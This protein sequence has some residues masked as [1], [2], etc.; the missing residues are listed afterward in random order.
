MKIKGLTI[1]TT[2]QFVKRNF[3]DRYQE[4]IDALPVSSKA[5]MTNH[6]VVNEWYPIVESLT[7]PLRM[8]GEICYNSDWKKA[9][10]EMGR[11]DAE[12]ALTGIYKLYVRLGSPSHLISR[13]GRIMAAYYSDAELKLVHSEK[14]KV[15]LHIIRF[16]QADEAIEYNMAGWIQR[17]LEIS[18]CKDVDIVITKSLARKDQV[19][20]LIITW[21]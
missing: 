15:V 16:D 3:P 18:G 5:I 14:N 10:W 1:R 21:T 2:P 12:D 17:A 20:E 11:F 9:V 6:I 13:A 4:W 8:V 19:S 7:V